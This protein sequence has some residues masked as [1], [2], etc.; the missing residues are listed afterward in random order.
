[1]S[2][3]TPEENETP[4]CSNMRRA[5]SSAAETT[6]ARRWLPAVFLVVNDRVEV[7]GFKYNEEK[8]QPFEAI[9]VQLRRLHATK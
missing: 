6:L 7:K 2:K 3:P 8:I 9:G 4:Q 5:S 1:M